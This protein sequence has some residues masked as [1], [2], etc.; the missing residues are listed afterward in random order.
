MIK[1]Q[2][3]NQVA[4]LFLMLPIAAAL[5]VLPTAAIAQPAEAEL[6]SL[7][8]SSDGGLSAGTELQF[9]VEGA[10]RAVVRVR[11]DGVKRNIVLKETS[12]GVYTGAYTVTRQDRISED[13]PI[14]ATLRLRNRTVMANY[15]FPAGIS[16]PQ[17]AAAV[18][19]ALKI[20]RFFMAPIDKIEPGSELRFTLNGMP[21]GVAEFDIP[22]IADNVRMR[23]TRPGVYEGAYTLRRQDKLTP[24]RPIVATLRAGDRSVTSAMTAAPTADAK[25]PVIR[26]MAPRD[27][28]AVMDGRAIAVSGTFDDAGGVGVDPA[29]VRIML[30]GRNITADSQITPQF[31]TYRADLPLGRY[32]VDVTAKDRA[33]NAVHRTWSFD[34]VTP[35]GATPV[36]VPLQI[37]SHGNNAVIEGGST[38]VR[39]RTAPGALVDVKVVGIPPLVG[40][41]GMSQNVLQQRV[42]ADA[43]GNF[44]FTFA[45]Q[46]PL[47]GTRYEI[48]MESN[49][50]NM[51]AESMLVLFQKQG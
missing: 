36:G 1:A 47:P 27:G 26:N 42:Q 2:L 30:S 4:A 35:V 28:E 21:G 17:A 16:R 49:K 23:E 25:P 34:V 44:S 18:P 6:R 33:G 46:L 45:P 31:F 48:N 9:T 15:S 38:T 13:S 10:P 3:R 14:R 37:T 11:I 41:F 39:G 20:D 40:L 50:G 5:S 8:V 51:K 24:S 32:A 22:G 19:S 7:E 43:S 12:R 29:T